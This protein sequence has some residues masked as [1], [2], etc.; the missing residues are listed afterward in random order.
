MASMSVNWPES[1]SFNTYLAYK[2]P[3]NLEPIRKIVPENF[4]WDVNHPKSLVVICIEKLSENWMG[5]PTLDKLITKDRELFLQ[6]LDTNVPLQILVDNIKNDIF[7]KRYYKSKWSDSPV[8]TN[9]KRWINVFMEKYYAEI[10]ENMNPRQY[11]PE[12]VT[13]LVKLCGP[14][15]QSLSIRS[16]TPSDIPI[17]RTISPEMADLITTQQQSDTK[18]LKKNEILTRDHISLHAA[19]GSL[20]NL[21]ELHITFQLRFIGTEYRKDQFQFTNNDAKNLARGLEKCGQLKILRITRSDMNC[22]RVKYILRG[23]SDNQNIETLDFSHCK[24]GDEG[25]ASI[26]KFMLRHENLRS[27]ILAD[28]V[29]GPAGVENIAHSLNHLGCSIRNLDLRLNDRLGSEGIAHIAVT[30]ARGCNLTSLNISG[31][32]IKST[33]LKKAPTGVWS[34]TSADSP[35]TCG[36]LLARAIGLA[37]TPLR[38]LDISV[39]DIGSV[40][41]AF[42]HGILFY[43]EYMR[44]LLMIIMF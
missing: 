28:N 10:L 19:L 42:T 2:P 7:W 26:A 43:S 32:G 9:D 17:Q 8:I 35:P 3:S 23:L 38:A 4:D 24:I 16:L 20:T 34:T 5:Y 11:D 29:F 13:F 37:K 36:E 6:I 30:I 15:I 31:C 12:K 22:Q 39:N 21:V 33:P 41:Y 18:L 27:L 14:Y 40:S 25:A 44:S 1:I